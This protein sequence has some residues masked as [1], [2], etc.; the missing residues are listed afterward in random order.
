MVFRI[1][2]IIIFGFASF[3]IL[4]EDDLER[5]KVTGSHIKRL[6][7]EGTS[8]VTV[9]NREQL[10]LSGYSSLADIIRDLGIATSGVSRK[11]SLADGNGLAA[12]TFRGLPVGYTIILLNGK[13]IA[14]SIDLNLIPKSAIER[15]EIIK[16]GASAIYGSDAI[17]GVM[18]F[19]TKRGD[20]GA[21][22][23]VGG[24]LPEPFVLPKKYLKYQGWRSERWADVPQYQDKIFGFKGGESAFADFT[25]GWSGDTHQSLLG[26]SF[27]RNQSVE[28]QQR[29]HLMGT[30]ADKASFSRF[31][32]PGSY[33]L[34]GPFN[35]M[36]GCPK[37][38]LKV[39]DENKGTLCV[40]NY[41]GY[42]KYNPTVNA[43]SAFINT[44][45]D[46]DD[47]NEL[48]IQGMYA[49]ENS[50]GTLAPPPQS[51]A[52]KGFITV[53]GEVSD[54]RSGIWNK[55]VTALQKE[56]GLNL[57]EL[58]TFDYRL[59]DEIG[60]GRRIQDVNKHSFIVQAELTHY[61]SDSWN[62]DASL[63]SSGFY[64][65]Q[66]GKNYALI[67]KLLELD[68]NGK[69]KFN[70]FRP[71]GEKSDITY[72]LYNPTTDVMHSMTYFEGSINGELLSLGSLGTLSS[73]FG[74]R[75]GYEYWSA[76]FDSQT[77]DTKT[78][79]NDQWGGGS[80][81]SGSGGR[82]WVTGYS[83]FVLPLHFNF[84]HILELQAA[85]SIDHYQYVGLAAN[86]KLAFKWMPG[87]NMIQVRGSGGTGFKAPAVGYT[88]QNYRVIDHPYGVDYRVCPGAKKDCDK[89]TLKP[90]QAQYEFVYF[91]NQK[92]KPE[93]SKFYNIG[94]GL[95]PVKNVF[96][97]LDYFVNQ[98]DKR[99]L[100][101]QISE[102]TDLA[103]YHPEAFKDEFEAEYSTEII[104][105]SDGSSL[106]AIKSKIYNFGSVRNRGLEASLN[107]Q[108]PVF[109]SS[110]FFLGTQA[111]Y[112]IESLVKRPYLEEEFVSQLGNWGVPPYVLQS[113]LG[114]KYKNGVQWFLSGKLTGQF[115]QKASDKEAPDDFLRRSVKMAVKTVQ[116]Q[117]SKNKKEVKK[118]L[119]SEVCVAY[120]DASEGAICQVAHHL[121]LDFSLF[122]PLS[123]VDGDPN[124]NL[125]FK[126]ENVLN[127]ALPE[128][129]IGGNQQENINGIRANGFV[130]VGM[131]NG[132]NGRAFTIQVNHKF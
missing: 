119:K 11:F 42:M 80:G 31:G 41:F 37:N 14:N 51:L 28:M 24:Y 87:N 128:H 84:N 110:S 74:G 118:A 23:S 79:I 45:L 92:L 125:L 91:G 122:L 115:N 101:P 81:E 21:Q 2:S 68:E 96:L 104:D 17:G 131:Y 73:A 32:S 44:D 99:I 58:D 29:P 72:A 4:A 18:N 86:P 111:T 33:S 65:A 77:W 22:F 6:N 25:Y 82:Y 67:S 36:P 78:N 105:D 75:G 120:N 62:I 40:F 56:S 46:L 76:E 66:K 95:E 38:K 90:T 19:I 93:Q 3:T 123:A 20:V 27:Q 88:L 64:L 83:E 10:D 69:A 50:T 39:L 9:I 124:T 98:V 85:G 52:K 70:P 12:T 15:I 59:V 112:Y 71:K 113:S 49:L 129:R 48:F 30:D 55:W 16:D 34:G 126:I 35:P 60:A 8:P 116:K 61:L 121:N 13:R 132:V 106:R 1:L 97:G 5:I 130:P 102:I 7:Q 100:E 57:S 103:R 107:M 108:F 26:V 43:L 63:N 127:T 89:E 94:I 53:L 47:D 109:T 117:F 114:M 54:T